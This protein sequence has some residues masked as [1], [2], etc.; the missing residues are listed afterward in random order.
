MGIQ[1]GSLQGEGEVGLGMRH[2]QSGE[3]GDGMRSGAGT[4][5]ELS[6]REAASLGPQK[7][8]GTL[9]IDVWF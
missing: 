9:V 5:P 8:T 4:L 6:V 1:S 7:I 3:E 2:L